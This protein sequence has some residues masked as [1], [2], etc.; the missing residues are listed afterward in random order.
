MSV[1]CVIWFHV[2]IQVSS[3][4]WT[5]NCRFPN[6]VERVIAK[7]SFGRVLFGCFFKK[8]SF[9]FLFFIFFSNC[10]CNNVIQLKKIIMTWFWRPRMERRE[11]LANRTR[12]T[13]EWTRERFLCRPTFSRV[14]WQLFALLLGIL[15]YDWNVRFNYISVS[16]Y[17]QF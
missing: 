4:F 3:F 17:F 13:A 15:I 7:I 12:E 14:V 1:L 5:L 9:Y 16:H 6:V 2:G 11:F 10:V 8:N